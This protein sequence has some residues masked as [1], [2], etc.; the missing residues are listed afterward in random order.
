MLAGQQWGPPL[1]VPEGE[2]YVEVAVQRPELLDLGTVLKPQHL[3]TAIEA[4][5]IKREGLLTVEKK[6]F[7]D[8]AL[9]QNHG[10]QRKL[11]GH[12]MKQRPL[13]TDHP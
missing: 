10:R 1:E 8:G 4:G 12:E 7:C 2:H 11:R 6:P 13:P 5:V 9:R 3:L